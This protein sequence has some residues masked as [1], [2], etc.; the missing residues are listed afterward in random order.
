MSALR[1]MDSVHVHVPN[2]AHTEVKA[3]KVC[4]CQ[5]SGKG[6]V[7][8]PL[9][10]F[11]PESVNETEIGKKVITAAEDLLEKEQFGTC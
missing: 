4:M 5:A 6:V 1:M 8:P 3:R 11:A 10:A 2:S 9:W 7:W